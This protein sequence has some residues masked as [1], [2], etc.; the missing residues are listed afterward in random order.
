MRGREWTR[1][2]R[3]S[4]IRARSR[5]PLGRGAAGVPSARQ[6][7]GGTRRSLRVP[8]AIRP[9][10]PRTTRRS[11][12]CPPTAA[13]RIWSRRCCCWRRARR[14]AFIAL[15]VVLQ[16]HT[17]LLGL[18]MG[19]ALLLLAAARSSPGSSSCRRRPRSR[20]AISCSATTR[21]RD[22]RDRR[23]RR[24]GDL[25]PRSAH[26]N[27][28]AGRRSR[29]RRRR[30]AARIAG[31][32]VRRPASLTVARGIRLVDD[33]GNV[34][35]ASDI[36]IGAFY[37]ALPEGRERREPGRRPARHP[38]PRTMIDLPAAAARRGRRRGSWRYSKICPHAGCAISLYRYPPYS[39][40]GPEQPAFTCPC[41]YSTFTPADGGR[42]CSDPPG[43]SCPNCR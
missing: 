20:P 5:W 7:A 23:V 39:T 33:T 30:S 19:S 35:A 37:T 36:Q 6:A 11:A 34:Y 16:T 41:H 12:A 2:G 13:M 14:F 40:D 4:R 25:P 38:A 18:A 32:P 22:R 27:R 29:P 17:Q 21:P 10:R 26:R 31:T 1:P 8:P 9:A 3:P 43:A 24:G 42:S 28:R 15:Y